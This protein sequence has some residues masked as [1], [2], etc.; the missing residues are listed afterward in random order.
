MIWIRIL[1]INYIDIIIFRFQ[2]LHQKHLKQDAKLLESIMNAK[3]TIMMTLDQYIRTKQWGE[4]KKWK[5]YFFI[6]MITSE[7]NRE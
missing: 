6:F 1:N 7:S 2:L 4:R 3:V 5:W